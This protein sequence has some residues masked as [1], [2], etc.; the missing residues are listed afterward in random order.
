MMSCVSKI[1]RRAALRGTTC[2]HLFFSS[3]LRL[4]RRRSRSRGER[5]RERESRF[6]RSRSRSRDRERERA[7]FRRSRLGERD[8]ELRP[9]GVTEVTGVRSLSRTHARMH[10]W[11]EPVKR[12]PCRWQQRLGRSQPCRGGPSNDIGTA[13]WRG[14]QVSAS[15]HRAAHSQQTLL[16]TGRAWTD[17]RGSGCET[18]PRGPQPGAP[19][20]RR[21]KQTTDNDQ[22]AKRC[23]GARKKVR[24]RRRHKEARAAARAAM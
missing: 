9:T 3:R 12:G 7:F 2:A 10:T 18:S 15:Q 16:R 22:S 24:L 17:A 13:P 8:L 19:S 1:A 5:E 20:A 23:S 6:L 11:T 4:R 14:A 21:C